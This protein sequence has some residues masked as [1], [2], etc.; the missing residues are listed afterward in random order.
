MP[1]AS[2]F[3]QYAEE[4]LRWADQ[5]KSAEEREAYI[6]LACTWAQ[7]AIQSEAVFSDN[8]PKFKES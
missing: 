1:K 7:A 3:R 4:A 2:E 8:T 6:D 5:T